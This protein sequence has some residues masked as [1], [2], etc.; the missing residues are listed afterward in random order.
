MD[1]FDAGKKE[2]KKKLGTKYEGD[3]GRQRERKKERSRRTKKRKN[4]TK[5]MRR[6]S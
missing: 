1:H 6:E 2:G 3:K 5:K 4:E